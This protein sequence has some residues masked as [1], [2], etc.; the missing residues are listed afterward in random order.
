M[1]RWEDDGIL[2]V[3]N[4]RELL[5]MQHV[6]IPYAQWLCDQYVAHWNS[7]RIRR[8]GVPNA[9]FAHGLEDRKAFL[10]R[11]Q[12]DADGNILPPA[13]EGEAVRK[14]VIVRAIAS[15]GGLEAADAADEP[16]DQATVEPPEGDIPWWRNGLSAILT[17]HVPPVTFA[18]PADSDTLSDEDGGDEEYEPEAAEPKLRAAYLRARAVVEEMADYY[19]HH[20]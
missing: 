8:V 17:E 1:R 5:A 3:A 14:E 18:A 6:I 4:K 16:A 13:I 10:Q 20:A 11:V 19:A 2:S 9:L 12:S 7:H 15:M